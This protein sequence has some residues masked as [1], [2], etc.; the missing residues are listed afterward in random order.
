MIA[1]GPMT[2]PRDVLSSVRRELARFP[3]VL[4]ALLKDLDAATWRARP[5]PAE[6]APVEIVCH[7]RDEEVEDFGARI[8]IVL[9]GGAAFSPIDPER[10]AAER[11]Y[12]ETDGPQALA[13]FRD[14]RVT[15][16]DSLDAIAPAR[17]SAAVDHPR[18]GAL[19]GLD[20][21]V[22]WVEHDRLHLAQLAATLARLWA[23]RW[24][25]LRTDYAGPIPYSTP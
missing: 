11:R 1:S 24:A 3:P 13:A 9:E 4:E 12:L 5:T 21:L 17:L 22:A 20:L 19:S 8:K 18:A 14:R 6:W 23:T 7:L 16:L 2:A 15:S 10:W 25:P